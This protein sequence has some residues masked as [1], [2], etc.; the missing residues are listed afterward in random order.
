MKGDKEKN[1]L[2]IQDIS[3]NDKDYTIS[4]FRYFFSLYIEKKEYKSFIKFILIFI[5][6]IQLISYA[7]SSLHY[8][9]WKIE[10]KSIKIIS[11][12]IGGF[13]L[14]V[15]IQYIDYKIYTAI[16]YLLIALIFAFC[17]IVVLQILFIDSSS[18]IYNFSTNIIRITIDLGAIM[19]YIP[20]I[21][22]ILMPIKCV[23][24]Q[25]FGVKNGEECVEG[26]YYIKVILGIICSILFSGWCIFLINFSFYPFQKLDSTI[27]ISSNNDILIIIMKLFAVLQNLLITNEYLSI[28]ILLLIS[29]IMFFSCYN[30]STYNNNKIEIFIT[31]KNL[32]LFWTYFV[33]LF[34]KLFETIITKGYLYLL[35]FGYPIVIYL[36]IVIYRE[37]YFSSIYY[38][39]NIN[40]L[41][42]YIKKALFYMS[43]IDSFIERNRNMRIGNENEGQRSIILLKGNIKFHA[44]A[45]MEKDCPLKKFMC[46]EGNFNTQRQCLLNYMNIFFNIGLKLFPK[47]IYILMLYIQFNYSKKFNLN[48]VQTNLLFLK[49]LKCTIKEKYIIYCLEQNIRYNYDNG[50]EYNID[51]NK[52]NDSQSD[53]IEQK[54]QNLKYLIE[55]SIKLFGE[56]WGLFATNITSN[57]NTSKL[58]SLGKKLNIYLKEINNIWE[59]ELKNRTISNEYQAIV[60]LYSKF[61]QEI[62]WDRKKSKDVYKKL[63]SESL[64]NFLINDN[65]KLKEEK[66][67]YEANIQN[68]INNQDYI[69]LADS[70]EKGICKIIQCSASFSHLLSYQK[71]DL[72]GKPLEII[73]PNVLIRQYC[74]Y[75]E[76]FIKSIHNGEN[77]QKNL[78]YQE[79]DTNKN[80][81]LI[82]VKSRKGYI[83][84]LFVYLSILDDNDYSNSIIIKMKMEGKESKSEYAYYI[85]SNPEL[86]VE[87]ISSS[88]L[89]LGLTLDLLKK[90]VIK[91]DILIRT[92]NDTDL[93]IYEKY[94]N[95]IEE[96]KKITWVFPNV[97]YPKDNTYQK[98]EEEIE[99]LIEKSNK[100]KFNLQLRAFKIKDTEDVCLLFKITEI[101]VKN[102]KKKLNNDLFIPKNNKNLIMFDL[103]SLNYIRAFVVK[104]KSGFRNF[105]NLEQEKEKEKEIINEN[106]ME[107]QRTKKRKKSTGIE[108][109][110]SSEESEKNKFNII[111]TKEKIIE[112][113]VHNYIEIKNFL[114]SLPV[115]GSDV[116]LEKFRPNGEKYSASKI[117]ESLL[118][119]QINNFCKRVDEKLHLDQNL[120]RKKNKN[121][122]SNNIN[123]E[124]PQSLNI[125]NYLFSSNS[126]QSSAS[127]QPNSSSQG[128]ELNKGITSD[129]GATLANVFKANTVKYIRFLVTFIFIISFI[130]ILIVFLI[131]YRHVDKLRVKL[132]FLQ[133]AFTILNDILYSKYFLTEGVIANIFPMYLPV[134]I[135]G[136]KKNFFDDI[137]KELGFY[138]KE[139]TEA[140]NAFSS[141]DLCE[142]FKDFMANTKIIITTLTVDKKENLTLLFN[143][144]MTRIPASI[145]NLENDEN[146]I[147]MNN[148]DTYELMY[149]LINEYYFNWRKAVL[150]LLDDTLKSIELRIPLM[151]ITLC[152]L[153]VSIVILFIFIKLLS[154]FSIDRERPINL[155]LT[156]KKQVFENLKNSAENFSNKLLNKFFGNEDNEE[157]SQQDYQ[158]NIQQNDINIVKFKSANE[159]NLSIKRAFSFLNIIL[160]IIIFVS[161]N[162]LYFLIVFLDFESRMKSVYQFISLLDKNNKAQTHLLLSLNI[163]KSFLFNKDIPIL[164]ETDTKFK[165]FETF[166]T[167]TDRFEDSIIFTSRTTNYFMTGSYINKYDQYFKGDFSELIN[168]EYYHQNEHYLYHKIKNGIK[169]IIMRVF[170]IMNYFF[171]KYCNT[172]KKNNFNDNSDP[173]TGI[174]FILKGSEFKLYEMNMLLKVTV[175]AW[176]KGILDIMIKSYSSFQN[177][178]N[179]IFIIF[180]IGL[181]VFI[182]LYYT[183]IWKMYEEKLNA[184]LKGSEDLITLIPQEIKN[185]IIEKLNE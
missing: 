181:V 7:F 37:K 70:D 16:L 68:L 64:N 133:R 97:I 79:N 173:D 128:D 134:M 77:N 169:P 120:K 145:N 95:Y 112:L 126:S 20:V 125:N 102:Y 80:I 170:E 90:Y 144:G 38:T 100:K 51:N 163:F 96:P 109:Q 164:G 154:N 123:V 32:T 19:F 135:F 25:V 157:E 129:G 39:G 23:N 56:F 119:I 81:R 72:I 62:L 93:N 150:I 147:V 98:K 85:L 149:N 63:N 86:T 121:M 84:P 161:I 139:F 131:V 11:T 183:I 94:N 40:N 89:N 73:F 148:R 177:D 162:F 78:S 21:E 66:N 71:Y 88:A 26:I 141:N 13:R 127:A 132:E 175:R 110:E 22:T 104:I 36:S 156:L 15:L 160:I 171:I 114:N 14:S 116:V 172:T 117:A 33:L 87:N 34:S 35:L 9:S 67:T 53:I 31:I 69:L 159:Y 3:S 17:L 118:N 42:D 111:L 158:S 57:I 58:Y 6:T 46:N 5:E 146:S 54:Y 61:L 143:S 167:L 92:E 27:R 108:E 155:F 176:Y 138:R 75:I 2:F 180:F 59:N 178:G 48:T 166:L 103:L 174:S 152:Y 50:F 99:E 83:F 105:R 24:G 153:F 4:I 124:S 76:E 60:Q 165:F 179:F 10:L 182:I 65:K 12:I 28:T 151:L 74:K 55:N 185:I 91:I 52:D 107:N 8:N 49:T 43:L 30:E 82:L 45:C 168:Q 140:Y 44:Q 18:K 130:L 115:Y 136:G 113:Q 29:I 184:L 101:T 1:S 47:N 122:N 41:N 137:K 142:E 106:K